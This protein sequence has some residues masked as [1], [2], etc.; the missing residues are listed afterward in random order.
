MNYIDIIIISILALSIL[1]GFSNGFVKEAASLAALVLGIWGAIKFS[2][3]TSQKLYDFFDMSGRFTGIVA[4]IITFGLIVV[5]IHFIGLIFNKIINLTPLSL[6]NKFFGSALGLLKSALILSV[7]FCI[8]NAI[9]AKR[10]FLP[11]EK[12]EQSVFYTPISDIIPI[13]FPIIGEGTFKQS[14]D[15]FKKNSNDISI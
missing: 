7:I 15:K 11:K 12:I 2:S 3:F 5:I 1:Y 8:L 9:D 13:F 6:L 10:S 4:F 14:F